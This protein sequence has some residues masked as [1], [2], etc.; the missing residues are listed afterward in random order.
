MMGLRLLDRFRALTKPKV[1]FF[2]GW[3]RQIETRAILAGFIWLAGGG[4][5]KRSW[6]SIR[7]LRFA[8]GPDGFSEGE[9]NEVYLSVPR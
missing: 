1:E 2:K 8:D 4:L 6:R 9:G 3:E 5:E 7:P